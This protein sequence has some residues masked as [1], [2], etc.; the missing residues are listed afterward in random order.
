LGWVV[1]TSP[2]PNF[3]LPMDYWDQ[4]WYDDPSFDYDRV[5]W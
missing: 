1:D 2:T 4:D 5:Y 3:M